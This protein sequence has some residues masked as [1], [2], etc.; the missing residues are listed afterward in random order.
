MY[1]FSF[2][3]GRIGYIASVG[4]EGRILRMDDLAYCVAFSSV[5]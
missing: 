1:S 4:K 5:G 2:R 3:F